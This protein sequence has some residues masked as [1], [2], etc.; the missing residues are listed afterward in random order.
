[1]FPVCRQAGIWQLKINYKQMKLHVID[2]GN[3]MID[4][5]ALFGVIPKTMWEKVYPA[6]E[7]NRCNISMR[8]LLVDTGDRKILIDSGMG[9][10]Q[11]AS[12]FKY[13]YLNGDGELMKSIAKAGFSPDDITDVVH[14]H[15]HFDHCGGTLKKLDNGKIVSAFPNADLWV[16]K[17]HWDWATQPNKR[18]AS[19]FPSENILPMK[20]TG[21]LKFIENEGELFPGFEVRFANG[22]TRGQV[23][24]IIDYHGKK[25]VYCADLIPTMANI[26]LLFISAYDLFQLDVID[27]KEQ[28][29]NEAVDK[30]Y[31]LFFEHDLYN[32]CCT[33]QQSAKKIIAEK[34]FTLN[35]FQFS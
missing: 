29:L 14:T 18:E 31:T 21:R 8:S 13:D 32:E 12:F 11:D 20:E 4:G 25:L 7:K 2:C 27:E 17:V 24:P 33:V 1:M 15:L 16:S 22:H 30:Q 9:I 19:A 23:I 10:K 5:G 6:D 28:L 35:E 26:P 3:F 34:I